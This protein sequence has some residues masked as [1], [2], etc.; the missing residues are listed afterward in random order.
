[1]KLYAGDDITVFAT[2]PC[3]EMPRGEAERSAVS[4]LLAE[5]FAGGETPELEHAP[6]GAPRLKGSAAN[7]SVSHC[8]ELAVVALD[9]RGRAIGVDAESAGRGAQLRRVAAKFLP[10]E[11]MAA[12]CA[13]DAA[14]LRAWTLKE[15]MYKAMLTP[16]LPLAEIPLPALPAGIEP[17]PVVLECR[18]RRFKA[19]ALSAAGFAGAV[20]LVAEIY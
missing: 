16:G 18:G 14:L 20:T 1:M 7:V 8:R 15:A 12:W 4:A 5:A 2:S 6:S 17:G 9:G 11:Q 19:Q 13:S 3:V 10:E